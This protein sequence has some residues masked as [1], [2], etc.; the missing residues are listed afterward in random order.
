MGVRRT[1]RFRGSDV[2]RLE[3]P[4]HSPQVEDETR[5]KRGN[6][7]KLNAR[8]ADGSWETPDGS[9]RPNM[10]KSASG[11]AAQYLAEPL[12]GPAL[13]LIF[14]GLFRVLK[15]LFCHIKEN[16]II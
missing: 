9:V 4:G 8:A 15:T 6:K 11:L 10:K 1:P 16:F 3:P 7:R 5:T 2:K 12:Y 14:T 13:F